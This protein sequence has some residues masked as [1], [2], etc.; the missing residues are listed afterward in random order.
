MQRC[1]SC[2]PASSRY[3]AVHLQ[4]LLGRPAPS[5]SPFKRSVNRGT[6]P[7]D[8]P[9]FQTLVAGSNEPAAMRKHRVDSGGVVLRV[10]IRHRRSTP[11]DI[12]QNSRVAIITAWQPVQKWRV[13]I[14]DNPW[15]CR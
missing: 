8:E 14:S 6:L 9:V 15:E 10:V 7:S 3:R 4:L 12:A 1:G 11:T 2:P 5:C 13:V